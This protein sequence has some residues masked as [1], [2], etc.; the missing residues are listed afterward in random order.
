MPYQGMPRLLRTSSPCDTLKPTPLML[1]LALHASGMVKW[2][3]P[4]LAAVQPGDLGDQVVPV[5][6][7]PE[8]ILLRR[9]PAVVAGQVQDVD[10][11]EVG[12][13]VAVHQGVN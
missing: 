6:V 10:L 4:R 5:V 11:L 1:M 3:L 12:R 7:C 9:P 13:Q 2:T 8:V